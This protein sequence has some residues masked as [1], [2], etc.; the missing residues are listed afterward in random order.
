MSIK[1]FL[2]FE[3]D[4]YLHGLRRQASP[5][6]NMTKVF[7]INCLFHQLFVLVNTMKIQM[8]HLPLDC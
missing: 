8:L 1:R 4:D 7:H 2:V 3:K 6:F 5:N